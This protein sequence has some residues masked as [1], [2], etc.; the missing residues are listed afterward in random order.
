VQ[1]PVLLIHF[2]II[3]PD[4]LLALGEPEEPVKSPKV[5]LRRQVFLLSIDLGGS[6]Q[7]WLWTHPFLLHGSE[8]ETLS[9]LDIKV[10]ELMCIEQGITSPGIR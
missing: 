6:G 5:R 2:H 7:I 10:A 9:S 1:F 3:G 4:I 8:V